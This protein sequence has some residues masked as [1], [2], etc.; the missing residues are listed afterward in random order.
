MICLNGKVPQKVSTEIFYAFLT[1]VFT[2][3]SPPNKACPNRAAECRKN[4]INN[5][6]NYNSEC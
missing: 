5:K 4:N 1:V 3:G 6:N 2:G